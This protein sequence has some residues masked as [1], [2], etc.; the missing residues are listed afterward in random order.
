MG[1]L[2]RYLLILYPSLLAPQKPPVE[3]PKEREWG[4]L[5][6]EFTAATFVSDNVTPQSWVP[7]HPVMS[8]DCSNGYLGTDRKQ[9][10]QSKLVSLT[11]LCHFW[12]VANVP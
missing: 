2:K 7:L 3:L 6:H 9:S 11:N 8:L 1:E 4:Q 5:V 12:G 10:A